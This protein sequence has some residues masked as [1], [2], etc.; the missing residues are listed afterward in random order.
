MKGLNLIYMSTL[1]NIQA[2]DYQILPLT[3]PCL[4]HSS[5][6]SP[7][8]AFLLS[9][10]PTV[11]KKTEKE[12]WLNLSADAL[13][14]G[15]IIYQINGKLNKEQRLNCPDSHISGFLWTAKVSR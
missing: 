7:I 9:R 15:T 4:P 12:I 1:Q 3:F 5:S 10:H 6:L 14:W 8:L 11:D 13:V 2:T